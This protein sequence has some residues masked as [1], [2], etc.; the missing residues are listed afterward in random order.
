V[1]ILFYLTLLLFPIGAK[2]RDLTLKLGETKT[3]HR[4]QKIWVEKS[5]ILQI[6]ESK[7]VP[8]IKAVKSGTTLLKLDQDEIDVHVLSLDQ[9]RALRTLSSVMKNTLGLQIKTSK[10]NVLV[11]GHLLM[12][13]DLLTLYRQ[14]RDISCDYLLEVSMRPS[15]QL[16]IQKHL[17]DL[18][19]S[20][21]LPPQKLIFGDRI[22]SL[23]SEK[24][25]HSKQVTRL[26]RNFGIEVLKNSAGIEL[27]PLVRLQITVAEVKRNGFI[28]YGVEW[29]STYSAQVLP[30][31][32]A[33]ENPAFNLHLLEQEGL[34]KILASPNLICLSGKEA[35]FIAGG[36]FPIKIINSKMQDV[37]WKRYGIILK[38]KP[39][40]DFSGKM[41]I[42]IETEVST[43]DDSSKFDG[44]PGLLTN[45]VQSH[46]DL[47]ESRLIA[48]SGLIKNEQSQASQGLP[49]LS[50]IPILGPLFSSK[51][52]RENRTELV[53][54]V[55]PEVLSPGTLEARQ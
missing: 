8:V 48:L 31:S 32:Q 17:D 14:C 26:L 51:E 38:V 49:G 40:A 1:K 37:I 33:I 20:Q 2:A 55:K 23:V 39:I 28:K 52:F 53:I 15:L 5:K 25:L 47:S 18:F 12:W 22:Q 11:R 43:L 41:S 10:G 3:L 35:Q 54:F 13:Q 34:G 36:E 19:Q 6:K 27:S 29:P 21:G 44:L 24:G 50:R 9:E 45:R 16:E 4:A 42:S 30:H 7:S 46:F